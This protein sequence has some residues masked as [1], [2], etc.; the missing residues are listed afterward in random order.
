M[1]IERITPNQ[2]EVMADDDSRSIQN[3]IAL[4][5][6]TGVNRVVI[7]RVNART[8]EALWQ[9]ARTVLLPSEITVV[10]E[11]CHL[12]MADGVFCNM[13][14]NENARTE[15]G[16]RRDG[17]QHGIHLVGIGNAVLDGG[18]PNGLNEY[19]SGKDGMPFVHQNLTIYLHNVTDFSVTGFTVMNQRWWAMAFMFARNGRIADL[20]FRLTRH[21]IDTWETW[22]NQDGV[23]LRVGCS[24]IILENLE[25]EVGDDFIALTALSSPRFEEA[26]HVEGADRDIHDI[27]IR[28]IR[29]I[30]N[31][32]A[33]IRLLN[34]FGQKIYNISMEN[35]YDVS[36]PGMEAR[37]QMVLR[38][39]DDGNYYYRRDPA[40]RA[41]PGEMY[42]I[43]VN[44]IYSRAMCAVNTCVSVKNMTVRNVHVHSDGGYAFFCGYCTLNK[45]II[46]HPSRLEEYDAMRL[47]RFDSPKAEMENIQIENV[48]YTVD[49]GEYADAV[50]G[51]WNAKNK[52]VV[53]RNVM[54]DSDRPLIQY[55][56][57]EPISI[58]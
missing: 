1:N 52:S 45:V 36:R 54:N 2:P 39:G 25:G 34:H 5:K 28:D 43:S 19:T 12:R 44:N 53:V 51:V 3:A 11:D 50:V 8:G 4:A 10:L 17:E 26:E 47:E 35:I 15:F 48:Y 14:C 49:R 33:I 40:F 31:Q 38:I 21:A 18:E 58:Q 23:D 32:C 42:N 30:T 37:S 9:I 56:D 16:N 27:I 20:H 55:W 6:E 46:F 57:S 22:R 7:P 41:K 29:A 13:F 24:N